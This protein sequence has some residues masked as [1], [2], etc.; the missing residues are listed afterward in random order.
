VQ[1]PLLARSGLVQFLWGMQVQWDLTLAQ[2]LAE[3]GRQDMMSRVQGRYV[4][5]IPLT[6]Y[7]VPERLRGE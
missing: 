7:A 5:A 4:N 3:E 2:R 1:G 6:P